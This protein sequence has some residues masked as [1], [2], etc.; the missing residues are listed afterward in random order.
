MEAKYIEQ[1]GVSPLWEIQGWDLPDADFTPDK[2]H[3]HSDG[4]A[5]TPLRV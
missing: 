3:E 4:L 1:M 2:P 5:L